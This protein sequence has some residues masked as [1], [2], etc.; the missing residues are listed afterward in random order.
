MDCVFVMECRYY[1]CL[2]DI[3]NLFGTYYGRCIVSFIRGTSFIDMF[4]TTV[5]VDIF[6]ITYVSNFIATAHGETVALISKEKS[7]D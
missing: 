3:W 5:E 2:V 7:Y 1:N 6:P 4:P